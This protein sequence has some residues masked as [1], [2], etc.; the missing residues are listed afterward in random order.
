MIVGIGTDIVSI[1]RMAALYGRHGERVLEKVLAP[2]ERAD[3]RSA[4]DAAR[5]LAKRFA[6]KEALAKAWGTGLRAPLLLTSIAISHDALGKP[7]FAWSPELA[8]LLATRCWHTHVSLSDER[9]NV[10]AFVLIEQ[11]AYAPAVHTEPWI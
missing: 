1:P 3:C 4:Q 8:E 7:L 10:V 5:F 9:E 2:L 11:R 6:A